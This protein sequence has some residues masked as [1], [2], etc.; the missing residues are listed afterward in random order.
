MSLK[1]IIYK[2]KEVGKEREIERIVEAKKTEIMLGTIEAIFEVIGIDGENEKGD[3]VTSI[4]KAYKE[5]TDTLREMF[6]SITKEEWK[7]VSINNI[8]NV[9]LGV[10]GFAVDELK[11]IPTDP[12]A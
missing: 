11:T 10:A 2:E 8:I 12:N 4:T 5:T 1:I 7:R 6:P 9:A 3:I